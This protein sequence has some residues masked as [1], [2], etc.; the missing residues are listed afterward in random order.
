MGKEQQN[1]E[2]SEGVE[3]EEGK[4]KRQSLGHIKRRQ[5]MEDLDD[6][7]KEM[8]EDGEIQ[9]SPLAPKMLAL[10]SLYGG[11][12]IRRIFPNDQPLTTNTR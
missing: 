10:V 6:Q 1:N 11:D 9:D 3:S 12:K 2:E 8:E 7:V 4:K 5:L